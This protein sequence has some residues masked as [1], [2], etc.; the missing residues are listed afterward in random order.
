MENRDALHTRVAFDWEKGLVDKQQ[1][2]ALLGY[3]VTGDEAFAGQFHGTKTEAPEGELSQSQISE[4]KRLILRQW[5]RIGA[6][7]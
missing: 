1:A 7:A 5:G 6:S 4:I 3:A 2:R